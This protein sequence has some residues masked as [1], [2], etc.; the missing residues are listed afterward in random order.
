MRSTRFCQISRML[1]VPAPGFVNISPNVSAVA[2]A[3]ATGAECLGCD[4]A[5]KRSAM[6]W[7][8]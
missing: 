7:G 5:R 3:L 2:G 4:M 8:G 6:V 1:G